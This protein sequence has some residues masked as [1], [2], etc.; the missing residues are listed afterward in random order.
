MVEK[1]LGKNPA[2]TI[3][4][5]INLGQKPEPL[6]LSGD[7]L[8][9]FLR[10]ETLRPQNPENSVMMI[11]N[12]CT[13]VIQIIPTKSSKILKLKIEFSKKFSKDF[14]PNLWMVYKRNKI[15]TLYNTGLC[16]CIPPCY[17]YETYIDSDD[18]QISEDQLKS[19][20][21]TIPSIGNVEVTDVD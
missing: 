8:E 7:F 1:T 19:E 5:M 16:F 9:T 4:Q 11:L 21:L 20:L 3:A 6:F 15:K 13:K 17:P 12:P 14:L 2:V 10:S 18:L